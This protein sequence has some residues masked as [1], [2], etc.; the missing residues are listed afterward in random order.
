MN[1]YMSDN[2]LYICNG[3]AYHEQTAENGNVIFQVLNYSIKYLEKHAILIVW[4]CK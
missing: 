4:L 3:V 1:M 2:L